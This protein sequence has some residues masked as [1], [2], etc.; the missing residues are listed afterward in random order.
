MN[1]YYIYNM[2]MLYI[3]LV[4][5]TYTTIYMIV[6]TVVSIPSNSSSSLHQRRCGSVPLEPR[7]F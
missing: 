3:S 5:Y 6:M 1:K 7:P 2:C 4:K